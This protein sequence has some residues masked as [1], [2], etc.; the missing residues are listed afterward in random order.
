[1]E[2]R[3]RVLPDLLFPAVAVRYQ[4]RGTVTR[5]ICTKWNIIRSSVAHLEARFV[6]SIGYR[7]H[8][9]NERQEVLLVGKKD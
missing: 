7:K 9:L 8:V 2:I 4:K 3:V 5:F 1:L 6:Q